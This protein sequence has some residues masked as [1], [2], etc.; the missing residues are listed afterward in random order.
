MWKTLSK[1]EFGTV[2]AKKASKAG[3]NKWAVQWPY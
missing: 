2:Y 3:S 1:K